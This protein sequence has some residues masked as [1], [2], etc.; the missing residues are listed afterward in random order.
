MASHT[1]RLEGVR[2]DVRELEE[3]IYTHTP[4]KYPTCDKEV[5]KLTAEGFQERTCS[6]K[7]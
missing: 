6:G 4:I 2:K 7:L 5:V 3:Q 1:R